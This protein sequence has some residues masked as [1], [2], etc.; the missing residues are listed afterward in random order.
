M[1]PSTGEVSVPRDVL[2][3]YPH[4]N[5]VSPLKKI[6]T[7]SASD[8]QKRSNGKT[9]SAL[10]RDTIRTEQN[11]S[12][13]YLSVGRVLESLSSKLRWQWLLGINQRT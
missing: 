10:D 3:A 11:T 6:H 9:S 13:N 5:V 1:E 8:F 12:P 2:Y 4:S 7:F